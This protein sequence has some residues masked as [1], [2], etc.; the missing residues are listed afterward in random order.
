HRALPSFPTRR[1]SDLL[2]NARYSQRGL[3]CSV[4]QPH[5]DRRTAEIQWRSASVAHWRLLP[6]APETPQRTFPSLTFPLESE[7]VFCNNLRDRKST[8]L[9][10]SHLVI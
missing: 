7:P 8:R 9:N 10:S 6:R 4:S 2:Q 3:R 5:T 1:S